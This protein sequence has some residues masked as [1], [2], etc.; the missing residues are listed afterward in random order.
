ML[1]PM[2][3]NED[4]EVVTDDDILS[5]AERTLWKEQFKKKNGMIEIDS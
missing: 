1:I 3:R 2:R 5:I 4:K